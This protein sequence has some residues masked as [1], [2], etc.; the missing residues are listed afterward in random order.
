MDGLCLTGRIPYPGGTN[1]VAVRLLP[2][3]YRFADSVQV[4]SSPCGIVVT[5][6]GLYNDPGSGA[7]VAPTEY[8]ARWSDPAYENLVQDRFGAMKQGDFQGRHGFIFHESCWYLLEKVFEPSQVPFDR[9]FEVCS[10]FPIPSARSTIDWGH[11]YGGL[12]LIHGRDAFP[13]E[14]D[15]TI[16]TSSPFSHVFNADPADSSES[17]R[18]LADDPKQP[19]NTIELCLD[20]TQ[21]TTDCFR[22]LPEELCVAIATWLPTTDALRSRYVSR[23]FWPI[24][25]IQQFWA[26]RFR[27]FS[28]RA[29]LFEAR[30]DET[31]H[32]WRWLYHRT[33]DTRIG[34]SLQNRKRIW[35]LLAELQELLRLQWHDH[36]SWST[37]ALYS[38]QESWIRVSGE[39]GSQIGQR[40]PSTFRHGCRLQRRSRLSV[41]RHVSRV[42]VS[43]VSIANIGYVTGIKIVDRAGRII[44]CGYWASSERS[45]ELSG[46]SGFEL[47]VGSGGI[48]ALQCIDEEGTAHG[49][50]GNPEDSPRTRRMVF[51]G[52]LAFLDIGFDVR[53]AADLLSDLY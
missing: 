32:D 45:A 51:S 6:V 1:F 43:Y 16:K 44:Q 5:G 17:L 8:W 46:L 15:L 52:P 49:W 20:S 36:G 2:L 31:S 37:G 39:L 22:A 11:S 28:E 38:V 14:E 24:Y 42:S 7:F 12:L 47:A 34:L 35:G 21:Y 19:A 9:I 30:D 23:A 13:W 27:I 40:D 29:W 4:Y 41:P 50:L 48:H 53:Q 25:Y 33:N 26:S 10:S 18:I 3:G